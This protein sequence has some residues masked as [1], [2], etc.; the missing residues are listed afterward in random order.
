MYFQCNVIGW[1]NL[2]IEQMNDILY[3]F[4]IL[5]QHNN[6]IEHWVSES[7]TFQQNFAFS[8][9]SSVFTVKY[10]DYNEFS[11]EYIMFLFQNYAKL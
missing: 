6:E 7:L 4:F 8:L 9:Q 11:Y 2:L 3:G 1:S 5:V 10:L